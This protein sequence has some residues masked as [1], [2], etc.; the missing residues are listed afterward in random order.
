MKYRLIMNPSSRSGKGRLLWE[1]WFAELNA[2]EVDYEF[3]ISESIEQCEKLACEAGD[4]EVVVAVGGDGTINAVINGAARNP[5][6]N[7]QMGV[8]Y[9]GTSP[10]FCKFHGLEL[11]PDNAVDLLLSGECQDIDIVEIDHI[12]VNGNEK[13]S[14]FACSC[15]IG[16]GREVAETANK[17]RRYAGDKPGTALALVK[18]ILKGHKYDFKLNF[19]SE[20]CSLYSSNHL[21]II[22]N[23]YIASGLKLDLE[24]MP[25][26]RKLGVWALSNFSRLGM[27]KLFPQFYTGKAGRGGKGIYARVTDEEIELL[28]PA[29][30]SIEFDGDYHGQLPLKARIADKKIRLRGIRP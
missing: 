18:A 2:A 12:D 10:D 8:L 15:N 7:L 1:T 13:R 16:L 27:F 11:N 17:I 14:Y 21:A 26:D 29:G 4:F 23:P 20:I 24:L 19:E 9:A 3:F 22:K 30:T 6:E 28:E 5:D 25:N